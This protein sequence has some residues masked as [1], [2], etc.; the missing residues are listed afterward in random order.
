MKFTGRKI[1]KDPALPITNLYTHVVMKDGVLSFEPLS[2][3][4]AG[5]TLSSDIHLDGSTDAAQGPFLDLGAASEAQGI[6]ARP[7]RRCSRR[8]AK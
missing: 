6:V 4:V 8:W 5:G 2:F 3:G 7:S 1:I